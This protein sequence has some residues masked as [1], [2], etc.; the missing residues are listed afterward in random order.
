MEFFEIG[1]AHLGYREGK[2]AVE[3]PQYTEAVRTSGSFLL[4]AG[5]VWGLACSPASRPNGDPFSGYEL[6]DLTHAFD[7]ETVFWPTGQPFQHR[8][9]AWGDQP[10]GYWYSSYDLAMSEH[11]GTHLDA[12]IHFAEGK[13]AV[14]DLQLD[15]LVG[16]VAVV[17]AVRQCQA[18]PDYAVSAADLDAFERRHGP[19][20]AGSAV[21]I[22]TGWSQRWPDTLRY[23]GD[24]TPGRADNLHF[25]GLAPDAAEW[26]VARGVRTVGIDT[27]S[28]DPGASTDFPVHRTL[29]AAS[30]AVLENVADLDR[31]PPTGAHLLAF[32]MK[33]GPGSGAPCRIAALVP[34]N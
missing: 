16:P 29:A 28:I 8:R 17:D 6:V 19:V 30:I 3:R 2:V 18:N 32:P 34:M 33:I 11:S 5:V 12:P 7:A 25:P 9:T 1:I 23:L 27:A 26:L 10:G 14:G 13:P 31:L 15:D 21:L 22:R 24:D 20:A 4:V